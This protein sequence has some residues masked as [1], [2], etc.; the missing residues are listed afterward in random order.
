MLANNVKPHVMHSPMWQVTKEIPMF[1]K[2]LSIPAI[3]ALI[4]GAGVVHAQPATSEDAHIPQSAADIDMAMKDKF[5]SAYGDIMEIQM[6]YAER[7]QTVTDQEQASMLQQEAQREMQEAV[8]SNDITIQQYNQ[9]IQL[10]AADEELMA[11]L[12]TAIAEEMES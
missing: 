5:V 6:D 10:A 2:L 1:K 12:E 7:L 3:F 4:L 9:I 8:A 11:E